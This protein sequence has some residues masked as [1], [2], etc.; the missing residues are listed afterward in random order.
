MEDAEK[1]R[2]QN[3][4]DLIKQMEEAATEEPKKR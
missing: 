4:E 3:M 1:E 2:L